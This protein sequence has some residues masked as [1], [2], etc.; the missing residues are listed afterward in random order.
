MSRRV[1]TRK[2][3]VAPIVRGHGVS[4]DGTPIAYS[5]LE[6]EQHHRSAVHA[7]TSR[8]P[9]DRRSPSGTQMNARVGGS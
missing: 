4:E 2:V 6:K 8:L 5:A 1:G 3:T 7:V 9:H